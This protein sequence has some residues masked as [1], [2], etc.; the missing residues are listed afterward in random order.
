MLQIMI[1]RLSWRVSGDRYAGEFPRELFRKHGVKYELAKLTKSDLFRDLLPLLNSGRITLPRHDR[2]IAQLVGLERQ[3]SRLGKD[4]ISH[5]AVAGAHDDVAN[6]CAG[7]ASLC[8]KPVYDSN[9]EGW[10]DAPMPEPLTTG[11]RDF[12]GMRFIS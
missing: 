3:V 5:A 12:F 8:R 7:V 1:K 10:Q 11:R 9:Y 2:L 4:T 6:A